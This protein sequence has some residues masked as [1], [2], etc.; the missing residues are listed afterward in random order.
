MDPLT[1]ALNLVTKIIEFRI[2]WWESLPANL[3]A[4]LAGKQA[5]AEL[6]WLSFLEKLVN[7]DANNH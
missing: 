3:R 1:A 7:V 4:E 2:A 6:R 5:E